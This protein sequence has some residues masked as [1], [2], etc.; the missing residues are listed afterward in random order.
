M[1]YS[2]VEDHRCKLAVPDWFCDELESKLGVEAKDKTQWPQ[3]WTRLQN[4]TLTFR[5]ASPKD[6][7]LCIGRR[8]DSPQLLAQCL[9]PEVW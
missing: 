5:K 3:I 4:V 7:G 9:L 6:V 1:G 8:I 2:K